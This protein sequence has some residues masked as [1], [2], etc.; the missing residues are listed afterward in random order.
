MAD[1]MTPPDHDAANSVLG[2]ISHKV[3]QLL[4]QHTAYDMLPVSSR[5]VVFDSSMQLTSGLSLLLQNGIDCAPIWDSTRNAYVGVLT[6]TDILCLIQYYYSNCTYSEA[7][8]EIGKI[9]LS[10]F[11]GLHQ[12]ITAKSPNTLHVHPM[13]TLYEACRILLNSD[14]CHLALVDLDTYSRQDSVVGMLSLY[15]VLRFIAKN[16]KDKRLLR[17]PL[18]QLNIGTYQEISTATMSTRVIEVIQ[19]FV[20][21]GISVVPILDEDGQVINVFEDADIM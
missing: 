17:E 2:P 1:G 5:L 15:T 20:E 6:V 8:E 16:I 18:S 12:K 21:K 14:Y 4:Q 10:S 9:Q 19:V 11:Q 7:M 13:S 3:T